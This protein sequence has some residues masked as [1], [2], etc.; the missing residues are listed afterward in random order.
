MSF[1]PL[2]FVPIAS[3]PGNTV[4]N[5]KCNA[6]HALKNRSGRRPATTINVDNIQKKLDEIRL[7]YTMKRF[8][9]YPL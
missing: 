9:S 8:M 2:F 3:F 1:G 7:L 4:R 6:S 5:R